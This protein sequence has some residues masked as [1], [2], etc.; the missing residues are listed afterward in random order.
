MEHD[1]ERLARTAYST[2]GGELYRFALACLH[3]DAA[4]QDVVQETV[5]RAW[6]A[7]DR[8]DPKRASL[9]TWL[10]A[11]ARNVVRDAAARRTRKDVTATAPTPARDPASQVI[12]RDLVERAL[13]TLGRE[14]R[15]AI[16]E[17]YLRDRPYR[18]VAAQLGVSEGTL[19]SRVFHGLKQL[20]ATVDA[21]EGRR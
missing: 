3:D 5:V 6:R 17:T 9:R 13:L 15:E 18:E 20:R 21:M 16:V 12:D 8:F 7:A 1:R 2:H 4:A 19:R 14:H 10:F 11:I